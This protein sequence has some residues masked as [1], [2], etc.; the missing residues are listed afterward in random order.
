MGPR[1][2]L[3][4]NR[5]LEM[6]T[7]PWRERL[8]ERTRV[9][10]FGDGE[11]L[12]EEGDEADGIC[13][14]LE[15]RVA[16]VRLLPPEQWITIHEVDAGDFFGE[17]AVLDR[18]GRS[19]AARAC[20]PVEVGRIP[21][22]PLLEVLNE[23]PG[24]AILELFR[25]ITGQVR[26]SNDRFLEEIV[27]RE[28]LATL[29]GMA[30]SIIHD[31]K[32]PLTGVA[33][34]SQLL[35]RNH[36]DEEDVA[37]YCHR[38]RQ[39]SLRMTA[40][41]QELLDFS[42]GRPELRCGDVDLRELIAELGELN[43]DY[44]EAK[45][46][47]FEVGP[48]EGLLWAD[49]SRLLRVLQNLVSNA[50]AAFDGQAGTITVRTEPHHGREVALEVSDDGPGIPPEVLSRVFEPF[51]KS[52]RSPGSGLGMAIAKTVV[53]AH[54]GRIQARSVEGRGSTFRICLPLKAA[55]G[56]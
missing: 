18:R 38:I 36:P 43:R 15:G 10:R 13:M 5:F 22:E 26:N 8:L 52:V 6:F 3:E 40:L 47:R 35:E 2:S 32:S 4:E 44:F 16:L 25:V 1:R 17:L 24:S 34:A 11:L 19:T 48:A 45:C 30:A 50:V 7:P 37:Q 39:Q 41:V 53:E 42:R 54:G 20:G 12:F 14:M 28:R 31:F 9:E 23:A 46:V 21:N 29:G 56:T 49:R 27:R 55:P 33:L 51:F